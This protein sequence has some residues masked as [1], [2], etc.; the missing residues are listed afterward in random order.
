MD[1]LGKLLLF[2]RE[3]IYEEKKSDNVDYSF[4]RKTNKT[5]R[6]QHPH[7]ADISETQCLVELKDW[8]SMAILNSNLFH[9]TPH[10]L[11]PIPEALK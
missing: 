9:G 6:E 4:V 8:L 3:M 11:R 5:F 10:N 7:L 2:Q 1:G